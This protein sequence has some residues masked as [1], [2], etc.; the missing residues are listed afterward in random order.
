MVPLGV[1]AWSPNSVR[2]QLIPGRMRPVTGSAL[3]KPAGGFWTST[4]DEQ[5]GGGWLDWCT[6]EH[7]G[8]PPFSVWLLTP[9]PDA[10]I[11]TITCHADLLALAQ[12]YPLRKRWAV[13]WLAVG[14]DWDAVRLTEDAHW[15][16]RLFTKPDTYGWDC[17]STCWYRWRFTATEHYG[18]WTPQHERLEAL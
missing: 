9:D 6:R 10:R 8:T 17:E 11:Y 16:T 2:T 12:R 3:S 4:W 18:L 5:T 14:A 13:D 1:Q 7:F 15:A